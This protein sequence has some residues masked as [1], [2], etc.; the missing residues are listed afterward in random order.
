MIVVTETLYKNLKN[1]SIW[2]AIVLAVLVNPSHAQLKFSVIGDA[3]YTSAGEKKLIDDIDDNNCFSDASFLIHIGDIK[4]G[5]PCNESHYKNVASILKASEKPVF[6]I[7]GDNEW[8]DCENPGNAW[9]L[10]KEYFMNFESNFKHPFKVSR[11]HTRPENFSFTYDETLVIG[12]NNVGGK[13]HDSLEWV[14]RLNE[15]AIWIDSMLNTH[16]NEVRSAVIFSHAAPK[17]IS[18][19]ST[20]LKESVTAFA[21]PTL[22]VQGDSHKW[23]YKE[24]WLTSNMTLIIVDEGKTALPIVQ[25]QAPM[26]DSTRFRYEREGWALIDK[27]PETSVEKLVS[28]VTFPN[29]ITGNEIK[30][31]MDCEEKTITH[32]SLND[33][34]GRCV[35][36]EACIFSKNRTDLN[37]YL[38]QVIPGSYILN[39]VAYNKVIMQK[40]VIKL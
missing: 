18:N 20:R 1:R 10:W 4:S 9:Q 11:Q 36:K 30:I 38:E 23:V 37:L 39:I 16:K 27:C 24:Q 8:N 32:V 6:I 15:N 2:L 22:W 3:P 28:P 13:I 31:H 14:N 29:P 7:P 5:G 26:E 40:L 35:F 19:F 17:T 33:L 12:I 34:A 25:L 21:K